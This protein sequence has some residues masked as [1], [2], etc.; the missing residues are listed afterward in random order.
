MQSIRNGNKRGYKSKTLALLAIAFVTT[1]V[2]AGPPGPPRVG[3]PFDAERARTLQAEWAKANGLESHVVNAIGIKLVLIPGG[4]FD[5]GPNGSK[6]R[7][8]LAKPYYLGVTEVTL[9][10]YRKY[11]ANY[12]IDG[13]DPEFNDDDR[14]VAMV[15]WNEARDFCV[16]LSERPEEKKAG[17]FY[18]LPTEAQWEWAARAGTS[19]TR[20]FG[21][22]DKGQ[23]EH[24]WF[25]FTYTPNPKVESKGRGR[26]PVAKLKPNAWGLHDMLGNVWE[27][28]DDRRID[29]GTGETRDPVMRGGS[30][31]SGAFH[32]T[33]VAHDPGDANL[34]GDHIGFRIAC[35]AAK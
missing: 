33:A 12:K 21:D 16:W 1:S 32:C 10:Q 35:R 31:R 9:V 23:A 20:Y 7:V 28:C 18:H 30:W 14:P 17:R 3:L 27:W 26:Q 5:M 11:K 4:R 15:N 29:E 22:T 25:N 24:S 8:T 13:A 2:T 34:R 6:Y 19:T